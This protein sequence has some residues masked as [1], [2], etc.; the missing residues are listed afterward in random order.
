MVAGV[1]GGGYTVIVRRPLGGLV[2]R[3]VDGR[4]RGVELPARSPTAE[5]GGDGLQLLLSGA[6]VALVA[7]WAVVLT[8]LGAHRLRVDRRA[9]P[10]YLP[11]WLV[12]RQAVPFGWLVLTLFL[13]GGRMPWLLWLLSLV[14]AVLVVALW[15]RP[16]AASVLRAG[17]S[18]ALFGVGTWVVGALFL[19]LLRWGGHASWATYCWWALGWALTGS[20]A[21]GLIGAA[22]GPP[23]S[24]YP[25]PSPRP[26]ME[27]PSTLPAPPPTPPGSKPV[28][29]LGR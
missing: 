19:A 21:A 29:R 26:P 3:D 7:G 22:S 5:T 20:L 13:G 2:V 18:V 9:G 24:P 14:A 28:R 1:S 10:P 25:P 4:W 11:W 6:L 23:S 17:S 15:R 27:P 16:R 8:G 12:F